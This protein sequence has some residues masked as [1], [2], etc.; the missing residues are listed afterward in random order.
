[1]ETATHAERITQADRTTG[2]RKVIYTWKNPVLDKDWDGTAAGE[3]VELDF[4]HD[5]Q[6]KQ[7]T[8][9]IRL[10]WWQPNIAG[11]KV[12]VYAP[13]DN[14]TYPSSRFHNRVGVTRYSDK[15][16]AEFEAETLEL[17]S[18]LDMTQETVL[19]QLLRKVSSF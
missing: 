8:A 13:F 5:T 10:V 15:S 16:F 11:F 9:T 2:Y 18:S 19:T 4:R 7:Y 3:Q 6:R 12:T 1:M 14:V 17:I